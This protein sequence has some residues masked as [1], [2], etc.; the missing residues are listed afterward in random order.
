MSFQAMTWAI[1]QECGSAAGKLVLLMLANHA[2][3]HTGQCNPRHKTLAAECEMRV[4]TLKEHIRKLEERGLLA[5]VPRFAEGI[6]LPNH[7]VLAMP[8]SEGGGGDFHPG[9]GG[10]NRP[11]LPAK[12]APGVGVKIAPP[13]TRKDNLEMNLEGGTK[14]RESSDSLPREKKAETRKA[15]ED[16]QLARFLA[17]W[18]KMKAV[19]PWLPGLSVWGE[20]R[21]RNFRRILKDCDRE[22]PRKTWVLALKGMTDKRQRWEDG[23]RQG[24]DHLLIPKNF[25][26]YASWVDSQGSEYVWQS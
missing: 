17:D 11:P 14:E 10:E 25:L 21:G 6:Q 24:V 9:G 4:E 16:E 22:D 8:D 19:C 18:E 15:W 12:I 26:R 20:T 7:Y 3:G 1:Q 13:I 23:S 2:N 5:V